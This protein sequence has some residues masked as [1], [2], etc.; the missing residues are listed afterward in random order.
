MEEQESGTYSF[1]VVV[2]GDAGLS[3]R[4]LI[5]VTVDKDMAQ[6]LNRLAALTTWGWVLRL[7]DGEP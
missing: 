1:D 2:R 7:G 3:A 5:T 6:C 4:E